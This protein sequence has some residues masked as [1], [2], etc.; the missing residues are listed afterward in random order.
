[1]TDQIVIIDEAHSA[2]LDLP[3]FV[4]TL[5]LADLIPTLLSLSTARLPF[6]T[7][8]ISFQQVCIYVSKFRTK[9]STSNMLHLKRLVM[10]LDALQRYALEWKEKNG[11]ADASKV[12]VMT[13]ADLL[14]RLGRKVAGVN[15]LEIETYLKSSKVSQALL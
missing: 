8:S 10:F 6:S 11:K 3:P 5:I 4:A 7:L 12:E 2:S 14:D 13:V 1:L 15:L 9:L